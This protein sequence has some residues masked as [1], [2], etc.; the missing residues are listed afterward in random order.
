LWSQRKTLVARTE[1]TLSID[2]DAKCVFLAIFDGHG[3]KEAAKLAYR[4]Q[5][6][7]FTI[8]SKFV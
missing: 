8:Y 4:M 1:E 7:M 5:S 3:G 2:K 6:S